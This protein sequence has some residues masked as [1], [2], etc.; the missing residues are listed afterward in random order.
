[1]V[2]VVAARVGERVGFGGGRRRVRFG[3]AGE[4]DE[5]GEGGEEEVGE[6]GDRGGGFWV[7]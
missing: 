2:V 4:E 1:M 7:E 3:A 6:G 5:D